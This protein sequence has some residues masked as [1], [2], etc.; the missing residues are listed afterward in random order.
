MRRVLRWLGLLLLAIGFAWFVR[1]PAPTPPLGE[2]HPPRPRTEA[3]PL[4]VV[5]DPGHGGDDSGAMNGEILEKDLTLDVARRAGRLLR[6]AGFKIVMTRDDDRYVPL[7]ER[8]SLGNATP[9]SLFISIH[10]NEGS[11]PVASGI[12]TYYSPVQSSRSWLLSWLRF[13]PASGSRALTEK[14]ER[15]ASDLQ[16]AVI[17]QTGAVDRGI[18]TEAFYVIENVRHPAVLMEGGFITSKAD[19]AKLKT[20]EYRQQLAGAICDGVRA[21]HDAV[22]EGPR[23]LRARSRT[24]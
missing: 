21:Y 12:E 9:D 1:V 24:A 10:F 17:R 8:A 19:L 14:S 11:K 20:P 5:L 3:R 23:D 15:L 18:K 16:K 13:L 6:A 4:A 7:A 2:S 22:E